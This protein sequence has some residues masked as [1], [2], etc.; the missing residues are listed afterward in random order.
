M[1]CSCFFLWINVKKYKSVKILSLSCSLYFKV[2]TFLNSVNYD[3]PVQDTN[4]KIKTCL[5]IK[6]KKQQDLTSIHGK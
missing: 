1:V 6:K 5:S 4:I 3:I 2:V